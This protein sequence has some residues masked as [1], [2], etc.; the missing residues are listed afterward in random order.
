MWQSLSKHGQTLR[1][2][3]KGIGSNYDQTVAKLGQIMA[4]NGKPWLTLAERVAKRVKIVFE[5]CLNLGGA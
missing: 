4:N 2:F 1:R 5:T 3:P